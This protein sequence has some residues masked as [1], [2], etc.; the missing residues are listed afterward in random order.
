MENWI[1]IWMLLLEVSAFAYLLVMLIISL[2]WYFSKV[3]IPKPFSGL[4]KVSV[5]IAVRNEA[6]TILHL[7][8][9]LAKQN[10]PSK[11]FEVIII[12]DNSED[13]TI[14]IIEKFKIENPDLS[15]NIIHSQGEGK[16]EALKHGFEVS[17]NE[18]IITTDGDCQVDHD[19]IKNYVSFFENSES[20]MLF[21]SVF[22][23]NTKNLLQKIFT[24]EFSTLVASGAGSAGAGLPLMGNGA[25]L[26]FRKTAFE[27]VKERL[28]G[29]KFASGDDVFLM[30][31][32][33][34]YYG[35]NSVKF[36]KNKQSIVTTS[37]P[38]S[39]GKFVNQRIRWGSKAKAYKSIWALTVSLVVLLFNVLLGITAFLSFFKIWFLAVFALFVILKFLI[40]FPL[41]NSFLRFYNQR[42][43][44]LMLFPLEFVYPFYILLT[45]LFSIFI[46][47]QWKGRK[48]IK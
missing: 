33:A 3:F 38:D 20:Q 13:A 15:L 23:T 40:D 22:Y 44:A 17:N 31:S 43:S 9:S 6:N 12:D 45:A 24:L 37:A 10:Y 34:A 41:S 32:I 25:N 4:L 14:E 27:K 46:P 5:V 7:L 42:V 21:G 16:K 29:S 39:L 11:L 28:S 26:A 36:I 35:K 48:K 8:I 19:W 47:Y 18:I 30:H 1:R 2:G